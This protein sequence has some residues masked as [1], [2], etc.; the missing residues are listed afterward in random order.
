MIQRRNSVFQR[1]DNRRRYAAHTN[2]FVGYYPRHWCLYGRQDGRNIR[3]RR[4][5]GQVAY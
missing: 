5:H 1:R 2:T 3:V 4:G